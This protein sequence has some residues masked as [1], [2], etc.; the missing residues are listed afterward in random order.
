MKEREDRV[1]RDVKFIRVKQISYDCD[2]SGSDRSSF[3]IRQA[4]RYSNGLVIKVVE[5]LLLCMR[6]FQAIIIQN[7][8]T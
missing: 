3:W 1:V 5:N 2:G 4:S 7:S 8:I 6:K